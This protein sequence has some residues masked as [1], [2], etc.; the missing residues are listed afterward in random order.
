MATAG[1]SSRHAKFYSAAVLRLDPAFDPLRGE[2]E[3]ARLIADF[4]QAEKAGRQNDDSDSSVDSPY[5]E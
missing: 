1:Y 5:S 3:F 4:E 2:P